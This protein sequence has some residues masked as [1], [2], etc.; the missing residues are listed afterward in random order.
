MAV[1]LRE[2][3][4][5]LFSYTLLFTRSP[6]AQQ[7]PFS[8]IRTALNGLLEEQKVLVKR[9]D[10]AVPDYENARFAAVAWIDELIL[11]YAYGANRELVDQW[12]RSPLQVELY[13]TANAGEEFFEH[14]EQLSPTQKE[15]REIY[16]LCLCLGFR[17]RYYDDTQEYK[18]VALRREH[19]QHLPIPM[20]DL[21]DIEKK[22]ERVTPQP[23]EVPPP[24]PRPAPPSPSLL[25]PGVA[26]SVLAALLLYIFWPTTAPPP[27]PP[28]S[29]PQIADIEAAINPFTCCNITVADVQN[30]AVNLAGSIES[31]TQRQEV[32][33]KV[34]GVPGVTA[35]QDTF[36]VIP[37]PFC[38]VIELLTPFQR[39]SEESGFGLRIRPHKGCDATYVS[40]D[41]LVVDVGAQQPLQHVYVDYYV[42]DKEAVAHLLPN[43]KQSNNALKGA[44]QT[45]IGDA[46][47]EAQWKIEPPF[48]MEMVTVIASPQ[49]L[50]F[51]QP[52]LEPELAAPYI[53]ELR[54]V[55]PPDATTS[56]IAATYCF[57][58]STDR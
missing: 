54:R 43:P 18:L 48:G 55:L 17:G 22:K 2:V 42:A 9:H 45:T 28:P 7:R 35:V 26:L 20:L 27:P 37:R 25:W 51:A 14:L 3:F 31:E 46:K 23:Y 57:I 50:P 49:P 47:S 24:P 5:P 38:E 44:S 16:H 19:A 13:D 58:T 21:L 6:T 40:D 12:K 10:I 53:A 56:E 1:S 8:E 52:H 32:L 30:G 34:A 4:T 15:I 39:R 41:P 29:G 11:R 33:E 36:T